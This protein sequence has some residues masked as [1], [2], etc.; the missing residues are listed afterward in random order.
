MTLAY[1]YLRQIIY[2]Q[3]LEEAMLLTSLWVPGDRTKTKH[4]PFMVINQKQY[5]MAFEFYL[6][7]FTMEKYI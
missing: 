2:K 7:L 4:Q 5:W 3:K 6:L 1:R